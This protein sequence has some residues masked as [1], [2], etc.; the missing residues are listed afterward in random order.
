MISKTISDVIKNIENMIKILDNSEV[1]SLMSE[2]RAIG[3]RIAYKN[4]LMQLDCIHLTETA[5][6]LWDEK[7]AETHE[8]LTEI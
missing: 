3:A 4:C 2:E 7:T 5:N 6:K 8:K 1:V